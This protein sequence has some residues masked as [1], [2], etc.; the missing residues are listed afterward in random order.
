MLGTDVLGWADLRA[1]VKHLPIESAL[2]R[3][4]YPESSRW[5]VAEHLLADVSDSL[6]WLVW[7]RTDDGRRGRNRPEP[8]Q[9]PGVKSD[10]ERL[11]TATQLEQMNEFLG[12]TE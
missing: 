4:M 3:T 11:G 10:R 2:L 1:I 6:R 12:W 9:R 8:I 5:Q 7:A